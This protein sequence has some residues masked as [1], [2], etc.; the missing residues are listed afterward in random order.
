MSDYLHQEQTEFRNIV[1]L[2]G[3]NRYRVVLQRDGLIF[4]SNCKIIRIC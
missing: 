4:S 3:T 2:K 1:H